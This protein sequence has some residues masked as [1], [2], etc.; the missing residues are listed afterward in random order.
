[1]KVEET[2]YMVLSR[3]KNTGKDHN[4]KICNKSLYRLEDFKYLVITLI[5]KNCIY[6]K[7][8]LSSISVT[9]I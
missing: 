8:L 6:D 5:N 1:M 2:K 7:N 3:E 4:K 9:K